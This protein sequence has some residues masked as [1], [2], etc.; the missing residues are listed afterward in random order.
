MEARYL[1]EQGGSAG[2]TT[3]SVVLLFIFFKKC[4][5]LASG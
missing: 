3:I 2:R 5:L 4:S 1:S